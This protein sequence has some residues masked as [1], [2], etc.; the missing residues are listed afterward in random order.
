M[1][2]CLFPSK[3]SLMCNKLVILWGCSNT[4]DDYYHLSKNTEGKNKNIKKFYVYPSF[5]KFYS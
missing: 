5:V 4:L 2:F 3:Q 1:W